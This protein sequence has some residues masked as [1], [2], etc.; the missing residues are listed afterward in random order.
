MDKLITLKESQIPH[1]LAALEQALVGVQERLE[2]A[3]AAL[4]AVSVEH[5]ELLT[6]I[7][8]LKT[9]EK[10][11]E[12][13]ALYDGPVSE[14]F[15]KELDPISFVYP[16][17]KSWWDKIRWVLHKKQQVMT[18]VEI[19]GAILLFQQELTEGTPEYKLAINNIHATLSNK[20][21]DGKLNR[22]EGDPY[23]YGLIEWFDEN[24]V[25]IEKY[26]VTETF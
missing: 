18:S 20:V 16:A 4:L 5:R 1:V 21:K 3:K 26:D 19:V 13:T 2:A 15:G 23:D 9:D 11:I 8:S 7:S 14:I 10:M 6:L 12:E 25:L 17:N 24:D 22:I